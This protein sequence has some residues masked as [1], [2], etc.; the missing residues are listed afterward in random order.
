[1]S[2]TKMITELVCTYNMCRIG[3][4]TLIRMLLLFM[5]L[6]SSC[7][8]PLTHSLDEPLQSAVDK[9][10]EV[11]DNGIYDI[12]ENSEIWQSVLQRVA[13]ELPREISE[14]IRVDAQSLALRAIATTGS[15]FRCNI[16]FLSNR[17]IQA[18]QRLKAKVLGTDLPILPPAF[19]QVDPPSIDLKVP[20]ETWSTAI[21]YGYDLD[22]KDTANESLKIMLLDNQGD[23]TL[24]PE[25]RIGRTTHYQ[26]TLN[27]GDMARE[28]YTNQI[29]KVVVSWEG[30]SEGYPQIVV[31]PWES[32]L[33][34]P[35]IFAIDTSDYMPPHVAGNK[36]FY[37]GDNSPTKLRLCGQL[38]IEEYVIYN[39][40]YMFAYQLHPDDNTA[41]EGWD[42]W[43]RAY[44][45]RSGYRIVGASPSVEFSCID[46]TVIVPEP[47]P[48]DLPG[49]EIVSRFKVWIDHPGDEAGNWTR[50]SVEWR[51]LNIT[52]EKDMPEWLR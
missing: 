34:S 43:R 32:H 5:L 31:I 16:D 23:S 7:N 28:L 40:V 17:A 2:E 49:G 18:L 48:F 46:R 35:E 52:L 44:E 21:L 3:L 30:T 1:M 19:C 20:P 13:D 24:L 41:V 26:I 37:T 22:H 42:E 29:S 4:A 27:L 10:V 47:P 50:V 38:R 39:R 14:T 15:E 36:D 8:I 11:I 9:A 25:S 45:A 6:L 12:T 33:L 51:E